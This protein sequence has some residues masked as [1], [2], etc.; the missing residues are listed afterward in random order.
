MNQ[1]T[2]EIDIRDIHPPADISLWPIAPAWWFLALFGILILCLA[3]F[4][5]KLRYQKV[6]QKRERVAAIKR[7][8]QKLSNQNSANA[9][10]AETAVL[11]KAIAKQITPSSVALSGSEWLEFVANNIKK[12]PLT[13]KEAELLNQKI[14]SDAVSAE[15]LAHFLNN[16]KKWV[17]KL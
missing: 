3:L 17:E 2:P 16:F 9:A 5:I 15:E 11:I 7:I 10:V 12:A 14:Y 6:L 13:E 1:N 4:W 8:E